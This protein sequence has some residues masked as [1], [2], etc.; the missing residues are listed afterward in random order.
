MAGGAA[1]V[2]GGV[3]GASTGAGEPLSRRAI[4]KHAAGG[5]DAIR[6]RGASYH[7]IL[8]VETTREGLAGRLSGLVLKRVLSAG[9]A[10]HVGNKRRIFR[11]P[12]ACPAHADSFARLGRVAR[13]VLKCC[14]KAAGL[15]DTV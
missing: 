15:A 9:A 5:A 6:R 11:N 1:G 2:L 4:L 8:R 12:K 10:H 7:H 13:S 3:G 14:T